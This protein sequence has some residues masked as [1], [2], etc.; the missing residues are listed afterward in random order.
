MRIN[1]SEARLVYIEGNENEREKMEAW[2]ERAKKVQPSIECIIEEEGDSH[3]IS[4]GITTDNWTT[5][6]ETIAALNETK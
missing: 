2:I 4:L 1:R 3:D 6:A 5:K